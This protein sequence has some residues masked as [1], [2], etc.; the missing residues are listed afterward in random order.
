MTHTWDGVRRKCL[1]DVDLDTGVG[2]RVCA[3]EVD[4]RGLCASAA[5]DLELSA[6]HL[7]Y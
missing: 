5:R 3:R 1:V 4:S 2:A 7:R 6:F